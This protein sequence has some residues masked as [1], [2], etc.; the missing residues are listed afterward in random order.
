[1][2]RE[3]T[4]CRICGGG[5]LSTLIEL[6][7]QYLT[8][9]FPKDPNQELTRGP[10]SLVRCT[11]CSLVQLL[12]SYDLTELYGDHYGYRSGLNKSMVA[13][14]Q[15]TVARL[16]GRVSLADGDIILDIGSND[17][18][19]LAS[20]DRDRFALV[21]FDPSADKFRKYYR[22]DARLVTDFFSA[23]RFGREFGKDARARVV[24]SLA[25][26]Y[27]LEDPL[28]F[29]TEVESILAAD[30]LWYFEQSYLPSMLASNAYDTICHE[31]LEYYAVHQIKWMTDRAGLKIVD[32][33]CNDINGGSF[34]VTVARRDAPYPE[35]VAVV[36]KFIEAERNKG[37]NTPAPYQAF[38]DRVLRHRDDLREKLTR[39]KSDGRRVIGYGA[40]TKGNVLLQYCG[41]DES[42]LP[43]IAEVNEEKFGCFTPGTRIPIVS[44]AEA[45]AAN[46]D[47]ML[48]LPWHF[49]ANIVQREAAYLARGGALLFPLPE[50]L[51]VTK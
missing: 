8:G 29:M 36:Q 31:H 24:T 44:E 32:I 25:M 20:Y 17:G 9:V 4:A 35:N 41:I 50:I 14:L 43:C 22:D 33:A 27:D 23:A 26:F 47:C 37:L 11:E 3:V 16:C 10:L 5:D 13:H 6:G 39:Y 28:R 49:R 2:Y 40:S 46:P 19:T 12:H 30:G 34:A 51:E 45:K 21:G 7:D 38:R 1:M 42:L 18:T 15:A 48:V